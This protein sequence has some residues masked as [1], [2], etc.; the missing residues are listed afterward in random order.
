[1]IINQKVV[2]DNVLIVVSDVYYG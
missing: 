2:Y 1:M